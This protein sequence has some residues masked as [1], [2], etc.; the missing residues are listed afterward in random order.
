MGLFDKLKDKIKNPAMQE[1]VKEQNL[2]DLLL[3]REFRFS[4]GY[5]QREFMSRAMD[6][7]IPE[8]NIALF[9]GYGELNGK[10]KKRLIPFA[11]NFSA[12][13]TIQGLEFSAARKSVQLKLEQVAP[14][15]IDWLTR[16]VVQRIPFLSCN[17]NLITCDLNQVPRLAEIFAYRVKGFS[18]WDFVTIKELSLKEGE[19]VGRVGV[20][21]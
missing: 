18:P 7:E 17:G 12:T 9:D 13:F 19:V 14:I 20:V 16:K 8:F 6:D 2:K 10:M 11:I 21:L 4:Q 3:K 5:L 15:D 1:L